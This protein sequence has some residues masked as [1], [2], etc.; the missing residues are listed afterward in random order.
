MFAG[1]FQGYFQGTVHVILLRM[2]DGACFAFRI[3][4]VWHH[5]IDCGFIPQFF[6]F[7]CLFF[8][9]FVVFSF[10]FHLSQHR[11]RTEYLQGCWRV[12]VCCASRIYLCRM[13]ITTMA[14]HCLGFLF[15][16]HCHVLLF[17]TR[18]SYYLCVVFIVVVTTELV[19]RMIRVSWW[20]TGRQNGYVYT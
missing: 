8:P 20:P 18:Y 7:F 1:Y 14:W 11:F 15:L 5:C 6:F 2:H 19:R 10:V 9:W 17:C 12:Y 4:D 3:V 16:L 13:H